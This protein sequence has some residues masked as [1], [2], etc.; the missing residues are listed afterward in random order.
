MSQPKFWFPDLL[1]CTNQHKKKFMNNFENYDY[2]SVR[3]LCLEIFYKAEKIAVLGDFDGLKSLNWFVGYI[4]SVKKEELYNYFCNSN[5]NLQIRNILILVCKHNKADFLDYLFNEESKIL[6]NLMVKLQIVSHTLIDEEQHNAFYYA[7]RSNNIILLDIL[8]HKWPNDYFNSNKEE[9]DKLLSSAYEELKLKNIL[10][11]DEMQVFVESLLI[12]LRFFH[13]SNSKPLLLSIDLIQNRIDVLIE[14][15]E[16]LKASASDKVD[17]QFLYLVKFI[18]RNVYVLKRQLKCTYSKLPWEEIEFCLISFVC[19]H[20]TDAEINYMYSSVLTKTKILVYLDIFSYSLKKECDYTKDLAIKKLCCYPKWKREDIIKNIISISPAFVELYADYKAIRDVH[21]LETVNKYIKLSLSADPNNKEGQLVVMRALQVCGEYFKNTVESPKLSS[22]TCEMLLSLLPK[23]TRNIIIDL[24]NSLSHSHSL[25][26]RL[27]IEKNVDPKFFENIQKDIKK[28]YAVITEILLKSKISGI[29][30]FMKKILDSE[31]VGEI[32]EN[33]SALRNLKFEG[34]LDSISLTNDIS[35]IEKL[36]KCLDGKISNKTYYETQLFD[37]F[38]HIIYSEKSKYIK[39]E[40]TYLLGIMNCVGVLKKIHNFDENEVRI[41]KTLTNKVLKN[42]STKVVQLED[43]EKIL[44]IFMKVIGC[45]SSKVNEDQQE[46]LETLNFKVVSFAESRAWD[47]KWVTKLRDTLNCFKKKQSI[48]SACFEKSIAD[49]VIQMEHLTSKVSVLEKALNRNNLISQLLHCFSTYKSDEKMQAVVEMLLLDIMSIL[50]DL[51][52]NLTDNLLSLDENSPVLVGRNLRNHLAHGNVLFDILQ[53]KPSLSIA[54]NAKKIISENLIQPKNIGK[55]ISNDPIKVKTKCVQELKIIEVQ[56]SLFDALK[57]C[58]LEDMKKS[59]KKGA[60]LQARNLQ[61]WTAWHFAAQGGNVEIGTFL[62]EQNLDV[63]GVNNHGQTP[64]HTAS[65]FGHK[66]MV[67]LLLKNGIDIQEVDFSFKTPLH[68]AAQNGHTDVVKILL[69]NKASTAFTDKHGRPPVYYAIKS[70]HR[71]VTELLLTKQDINM[72]IQLGGFTAMHV[73]AEL[74]HLELVNLFLKHKANVNAKADKLTTALHGAS[75]KG[76]METAM[77]LIL[78]GAEL[79]VQSDKGGTPLHYAVE[80]NSENIVKLLLDNGADVNVA[81]I[82]NFTP[83]NCA[84]RDGHLGIVK[85]LLEHKSDINH[86]TIYNTTSLY[87]ASENGHLSTV[88]FLLRNKASVHY[89]DLNGCSALH[90]A[91]HNGHVDIVKLL[92][93]SRAKIN[94]ID[95]NAITPLYWSSLN[96]KPD[97]VATLISLGADIECKGRDG[98]TGLHISCQKGHQAIV[99]Q[100]IENG[101]NLTV[102]N[103]KGFSPL[104]CAIEGNNIDIV[105]LLIKNGVNINFVNNFGFTALH[106]SALS[107]NEE[108]VRLFLKSSLNINDPCLLGL[109]PLHFAVQGNYREAVNTLIKAGANID[110]EDASGKTPL[111]FA[112]ENNSKD[113]AKDLVEYGADL[114][115]GSPLIGA[116]ANNFEDIALFLINNDSCKTKDKKTSTAA[117]FLAALDGQENIVNALLLK[118]ADINS[119]NDNNATALHISANQGH[120]DVVKVLLKYNSKLYKRVNNEGLTPLHLAVISGHDK[121]VSTLLNAGA[122]PCLADNYNQT[123][124]EL[125][126]A[127][128][129]FQIVKIILNQGNVN[130]NDKGK[131]GFTL[132]HIA[133]QMG[134]LA[135]A[136]ILVENGANIHAKNISGSK[137]IHIAARDGHLNVVKFYLDKNIQLNDIGVIGESLLH[138]AIRGGQLEIV[139]YLINQNID[140]NSSNYN[141]SK[142]LHIAAQYGYSDLIY[143]LLEN[144]AYLNAIEIN[145]ISAL[146][147]ARSCG[148]KKATKLLEITDKFFVV[149]KQNKILE[150]EKFLKEG[151]VVNVKSDADVTPLHYASWKGFDNIVNILLKYKANPNIKGKSGCTPLHYACK[152]GHFNIVKS[153]L[154]HKAAYNESCCNGKTA[155]DFATRPDITKLLSLINES[156]QNVQNGNIEVI[157]LLYEIKDKDILKI[158]MNACNKDNKTLFIAAIHSDFPKMKQLKQVFQDDMQAELLAAEVLCSQERYEEVLTLLKTVL[159]K[160]EDLF[161]LEHPDTLEMQ[162]MIGKV[163]YKQHKYKEALKVSESVYHKQKE[164]L[165][166]ENADTLNSKRLIALI[167]FRQSK[168][169]EALG[170]C[171]DILPKLKK[172]LGPNHSDVLDTQGEMA[173]VLHAL[174]KFDEA[175]K[176]NYQILKIR[177]KHDGS[178]HPTTLTIQNNIARILDDQGKDAEALELYKKVYEAR[179]KVLGPNHSDTLRTSYWIA[180]LTCK[181]GRAEESLKIYQ[182]IIERQREILGPNHPSVID[183]ERQIEATKYAVNQVDEISS[184]FSLQ[185]NLNNF[186]NAFKDMNP[187][188]YEN[189]VNVRDENSL[190]PLHYAASEGNEQLVKKLLR[191]GA[192][193]M[194]ISNKGNTALHIAASKGFDTIVDILLEHVNQHDLPKLNDFINAQTTNGK[195]SALHVAGNKNVA[196]SLLKNGAIY[197]IKNKKDETPLNVS[198]DADIVYLLSIIEEIFTCLD[199]QNILKTMQKLKPCE[200]FAAMNAHNSNGETILNKVAKLPE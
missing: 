194:L 59:I 119:T 140:V 35:E 16:K 69:R 53:N 175:L 4:S 40:N 176:I 114:N 33:I 184:N 136:E 122:N 178:N 74:G 120:N 86:N 93:G 158:I 152:Y 115:I 66:D 139:K 41:I 172:T 165:G 102:L 138:Y 169:E 118:G 154:L 147:I 129:K 104:F 42:M 61:L 92:V 91:A 107:G 128:D 28:I 191:Q 112:V 193:V 123:S 103:Q 198:K 106:I 24:R 81:D 51:N 45:I 20:T 25:G 134:H 153:L 36:V 54:I 65:A 39:V 149:V 10:L 143:L 84:A 197:N 57:N 1:K 98:S 189:D 22:S 127:H 137:P 68:V 79:N 94:G 113:I 9:L 117:L 47:V 144:G 125:A 151:A 37:E 124:I 132:L 200:I 13:N 12:D 177:N 52:K 90:I 141:L 185:D 82:L 19:S 179:K 174:F 168:H 77:A 109:V 14:S 2:E 110:A 7:V 133:A 15:I 190:T 58:N 96:N 142:P 150:T 181:K 56:N 171:E 121:V 164:V 34:S 170:L 83:L 97:V 162:L 3:K 95:M 135:I 161:G 145:N 8:I 159:E 195:T 160:R 62:V 46:K 11:T 70:N 173:R 80:F 180:S 6:W 73:A 156:F 126:V 49:K 30:I 78:A 38:Y 5:P 26:R 183:I 148:H 43:L 31:N 17:E 44:D 50:G 163:L 71:K 187:I 167:F 199:S 18:A 157:S 87:L 60:D 63:K 55:L 192:D 23:N 99:E 21:S 116:I 76:Q 108:M 29:K 48:S 111:C 166:E 72:S 32:K 64:M 131:D 130:V 85:L 188:A 88:E 182:D 155:L 186:P 146:E 75:L 196:I 27:E 100:L 105:K 67:Q 89:K 101:A